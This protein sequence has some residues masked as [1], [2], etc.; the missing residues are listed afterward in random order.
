[1]PANRPSC[2]VNGAATETAGSAAVPGD[3]NDALAI[4]VLPLRVEQYRLV[5]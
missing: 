2:S 1:M 5:R 4:Q 3:L